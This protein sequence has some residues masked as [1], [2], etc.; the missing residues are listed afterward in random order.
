MGWILLI[1]AFWLF[2]DAYIFT[3]MYHLRVV[4]TLFLPN[5]VLD[6]IVLSKIRNETEGKLRGFVSGGGVLPFHIDEF[7]NN[8]GIQVFEGYGMTE[9]SP[10]ISL[11]SFE[12][13]ISS[14]NGF[15]SFE[16][17]IA[18]RILPKPFE[19]GDELTAKLSVKRHIVTDKYKSLLNC[20]Y[21][22]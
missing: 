22:V 12:K 2:L 11:R 3:G 19:L 4:I 9:T 1:A 8:I 21:N 13:L 6:S 20:I 5:F 18:F 7:F 14:E 10:V 16:K 15:K 17:I